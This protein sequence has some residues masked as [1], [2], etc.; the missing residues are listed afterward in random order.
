MS[1]E[2]T[3]ALVAKVAILSR[4]EL[5]DEEA[6]EMK[7]HFQ[8]VLQFVEDLQELDLSEVDPSLFSIEASNVDREDEV[9][10][11]FTNAEALSAAPAS[12]PP[13][14]LVPRIVGGVGDAEG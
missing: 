3:D 7:E 12:E 10:T 13:Y 9:K 14:F 8:K 2:V 6:R 1:I 4:L 11:S 5:T